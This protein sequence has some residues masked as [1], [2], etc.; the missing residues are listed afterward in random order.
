MTA[1]GYDKSEIPQHV[2]YQDFTEMLHPED[3]QKAM[4][5]MFG[6]MYGAAV[7]YEVEYRIRAKHGGYRWY[8]VR[9]KITQREKQGGGLTQARIYA[10]RQADDQ[11]GSG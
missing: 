11:S 8:Y 3:D 7:F 2:S 6:H 9:G 4:N 5:T 1:L 10:A